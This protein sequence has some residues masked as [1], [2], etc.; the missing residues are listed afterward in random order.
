MSFKNAIFQMWGLD[1]FPKETPLVFYQGGKPIEPPLGIYDGL[2]IVLES[3]ASYIER[4]VPSKTLKLWRTQSPRHF[5]RGEWDHNG[6]CVFDRLLQ[7]HEIDLWFDPRFGGVNKEARLVIPGEAA[8]NLP[9]RFPIPIPARPPSTHY[10]PNPGR[11][12][13]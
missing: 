3:M 9:C 2:K 11:R 1:K 6:S 10:L 8:A 12:G 5:H 4:E 7:E 13:E